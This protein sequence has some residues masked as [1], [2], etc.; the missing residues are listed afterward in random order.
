MLLGG[1]LLLAAAVAVLLCLGTGNW[2]L[3]PVWLVA[4]AVLLVALAFGF[5]CF[6]C[7]IVDASKPQTH[8]SKFYRTMLGVYINFLVPV[9]GIRIHTA[10]TEKIPQ[11]GRFLLVS[12]HLHEAD[13][14]ILMRTF[15]KSQ[16]AFISKREA[17]SMFLVGKIMHK[18]LCQPINREN[19]REA[20]KTILK[21]IQLIKD[22]EVSVAV[23][24]EGY[25]RDNRKLHHFRHGVFKIA[26][27]AKVP[28][29]VC[30]LQ[31]THRIIANALKL[32]PTDVHLHLLDV[33]R[34][35]EYAGMTTVELS[36]KIYN[37]MADDL[38]PE[39]VAQEQN[40]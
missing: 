23:F 4:S 26:I 29:V 17:G 7:Q 19:D 14:A 6:M 20:L 25:I 27:K 28:I 32:K 40:A 8:D 24:P 33:I 10:G 34:P 3:L 9:L 16:L 36:E 39:L 30:T 15:P 11:E 5:L 22:D 35:E 1:I 37:M 38:G 18:L 21:C 13:P 12:N 31:N 2:W